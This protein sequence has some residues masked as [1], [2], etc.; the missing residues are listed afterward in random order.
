MSKTCFVRSAV[1]TD[2]G[3]H[4]AKRDPRDRDGMP[5]LWVEVIE[6]SAYDDLANKILAEVLTLITEVSNAYKDTTLMNHMYAANKCWQVVAAYRDGLDSTRNV[7]VPPVKSYPL[8]L[9]NAGEDSY[10]LMSLGHHDI[11]EFG[12]VVLKEHPRWSMSIPE[13]GW[14]VRAPKPGYSS[15]YYPCEKDHPK[16]VPMTFCREDYSEDS[17]SF[18]AK[19]QHHGSPTNEA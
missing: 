11:A 6:K 3:I 10:Q 2:S 4:Y 15:Y 14:Y 18:Y 9:I 1:F 8:D 7:H 19:L 16:A 5:G 12:R 17:K 13:H